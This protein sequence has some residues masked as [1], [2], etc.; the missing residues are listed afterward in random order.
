MSAEQIQVL[1]MVPALLLCALALIEMEMSFYRCSVCSRFKGVREY[2]Y[3]GI[4]YCRRCA[5]RNGYGK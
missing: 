5:K 4:N 3:A 1:C 2:G